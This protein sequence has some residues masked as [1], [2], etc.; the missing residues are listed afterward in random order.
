MEE[1]KNNWREELHKLD[2]YDGWLLPS[3]QASLQ[4]FIE[5]L[6]SCTIPIDVV[7]EHIH[8]WVQMNYRGSEGGWI[9]DDEVEASIMSYI[10][11]NHKKPLTESK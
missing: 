7:R 1:S 6:L 5:I 9:G 11:G 2:F 3:Q 10:E 4:G 8:D